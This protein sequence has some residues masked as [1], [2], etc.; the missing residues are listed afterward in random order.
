LRGTP[1]DR[2]DKSGDPGKAPHQVPQHI[3]QIRGITVIILTAGGRGHYARSQPRISLAQPSAVGLG[4][5]RSGPATLRGPPAAQDAGRRGPDLEKQYVTV[6]G[7]MGTTGTW[8]LLWILLALGLGVTGGF[9]IARG[10]RN[11]RTAAPPQVPPA[12]S[13]AV[14]GSQRCA[15]VAVCERR[16]QPGRLSAGQRRAGRL[17]RCHCQVLNVPGDV[18]RQGLPLGAPAP[19]RRGFIRHGIG[20]SSLSG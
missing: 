15:A 18:T 20:P 1:R 9:M 10:Q 11:C 14:A 17:T 7:M 16:N 5:R 4:H 2:Q 8:M 3:R 19:P 6:G 13:A 12:E